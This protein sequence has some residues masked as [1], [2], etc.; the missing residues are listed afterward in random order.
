MSILAVVLYGIQWAIAIASWLLFALCF[1]LLVETLA[2]LWPQR[3]ALLVP[4]ADLKAA[5]VI[6]AHDEELGLR[7]TLEPLL[8]LPYQ[9]VVVAD[10]CGDATAEVAR[11][12]GVTVLERQDAAKRGKGYA[13]DY[14]L[15]Y[16]APHQPDVVVF[17]DADCQVTADGVIQLVQWAI[18]TQ[19]PVQAKYLMINPTTN[20]KQQLSA[21]AF[22][23]KNQ[24]RLQGLSR[25]GG[26]IVLAGSGMGFPWATLQG[27]SLASG[28]IVEDMKLGIDLAIA[29][30]P[31]VFCPEVAVTSDLPIHQGAAQSQRKR[32]EHGHLQSIQTYV[33]QLLSAAIRQRRWDLGLMAWDLCI[34]PLSLL[35]MLWFV[36]WA[37]AALLQL[38]LSWVPL[39]AL[40]WALNG[41]GILNGAGVCLLGAIGLAW[42]RV[43]QQDISLGQL[44][45]VPF[46]VLGKLPLYLQFLT[47]PQQAWNRTER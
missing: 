13:M 7:K 27:M 22:K 14:G 20:A 11:S 38:S 40:P 3:R 19:R 5:V 32:W 2:F 36:A 30:K 21:F 24:V 45:K 25:L 1:L 8:T 44:L 29:G 47:N 33:P 35:V 26:A 15:N 4:I 42:L 17:L 43:G 41:F 16:L 46:Y 39:V 28:A 10:N 23:V 6:P 9:I 34:P 31:A 18:L 12:L 37:A